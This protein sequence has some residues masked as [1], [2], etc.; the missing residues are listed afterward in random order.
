MALERLSGMTGEAKAA[1]V[2]RLIRQEAQR[3][4]LWPP[5]IDRH[6][7]QAQ[8]QYQKAQAA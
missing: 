3:H 4:G 8:I 1:I 6:T 7:A 2:R 5:A